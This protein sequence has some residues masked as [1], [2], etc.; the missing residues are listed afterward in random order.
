MT[1]ETKLLF[2]EWWKST[3]GIYPGGKAI[4]RAAWEAALAQQA[5]PDP[6]SCQRCGKEDAEF[7]ARCSGIISDRMAQQAQPE[8]ACDGKMVRQVAMHPYIRANYCDTSAML[9]DLAIEIERLE[10]QES[11]II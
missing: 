7:C 8:Q 5:Q 2:D 10:N 4:A 9:E 11:R 6:D 1:N 3:G